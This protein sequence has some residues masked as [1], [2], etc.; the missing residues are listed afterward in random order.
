VV[1]AIRTPG[2][3]HW[4]NPVLIRQTI[5]REHKIIEELIKEHTIIMEHTMGHTIIKG[6]MVIKGHMIVAKL[7]EVVHIRLGFLLSILVRSLTLFNSHLDTFFVI[8]VR[9]F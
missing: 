1:L 5:I 8:G 6:H 7:T 3:E 4:T 2:L 9:S